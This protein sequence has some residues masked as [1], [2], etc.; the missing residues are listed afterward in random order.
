MFRPAVARRSISRPLRSRA[1]RSSLVA[2]EGSLSTS[3]PEFGGEARGR[4]LTPHSRRAPAIGAGGALEYLALA[5]IVGVRDAGLA[6]ASLTDSEHGFAC[7]A[8]EPAHHELNA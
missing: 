7:D 1:L 4:G 2:Q 3:S 5:Q 6:L 8:G